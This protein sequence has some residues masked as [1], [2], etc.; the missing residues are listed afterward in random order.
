MSAKICE[1]AREVAE[2]CTDPSPFLEWLAGLDYLQM[3]HRGL[4]PG[5]PQRRCLDGWEGF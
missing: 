4:I 1:E 2:D 3:I 5:P